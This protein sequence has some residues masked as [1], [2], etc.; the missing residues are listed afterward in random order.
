MISNWRRIAINSQ[1][2]LDVLALYLS[3]NQ[4][5]HYLRGALDAVE[6]RPQCDWRMLLLIVIVYLIRL[7]K[8]NPKGYGS[9][10]HH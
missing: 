10:C 3:L 9:H 1:H 4:F 6:T 2:T 8:I 5:I 7:S